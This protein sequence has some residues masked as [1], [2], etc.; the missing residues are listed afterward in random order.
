[1]KRKIV[2]IDED[3]CNGCGECAPACH[4]GAIQI[5]DGKA[6]LI[7]DKLCDGLGDCLGECPA[8]AITI[9]ERDT[10]A[11]D[12][13]AVQKHLAN[14][15]GEATPCS[16]GSLEESLPCGCPSSQ[17]KTINLNETAG[18]ADSDTASPNCLGHWPVQLT[19]VPP[20]AKFLQGADLL[21]TAHCVP[22][23]FG[24]FHR[25]LLKGKAVVIACPKLDDVQ[26]HLEKLAEIF[27][28]ADIRSAN[29]V[30]M[31]V[32]CC[33]ALKRIVEMAIDYSGKKIPLQETV[34]S[35]SGEIIS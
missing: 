9:E 25:S 15:K 17:V 16:A 31:E 27:K 11:Y 3:K 2:V 22:F 26:T 13:A 24:D 12:E 32:P 1:M 30:Y 7:A 8:G 33:S 29:V 4:E 5:V 35:T 18:S 34:I 19:L 23:A 28:T 10:D 21:I 20:Q 14:I 6:R